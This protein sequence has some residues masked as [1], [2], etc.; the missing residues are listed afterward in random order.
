ME[1]RVLGPVEVVAGGQPLALR[2]QK[3][4]TLLVALLVQ[5]NKIVATERLIDALWDE[6]P[7][8]TARAALQVHVSQLRKLLGRDRIVTNPHGYLLRVEAGEL[9]LER[10]ER[11]VGEARVAAGSAAA[12][13]LRQALAL[14]AGRPSRASSS[15]RSP[16]RR[17]RVS[18]SYGSARRSSESTRSSYSA[19][20]RNSCPS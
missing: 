6:Q 11:L 15:S 10:F 5:A 2:G 1:F 7:P 19:S 4:R 9:D 17:S 13:K 18:R 3:Q 14:W 8:E 12:T 20:I 16:S